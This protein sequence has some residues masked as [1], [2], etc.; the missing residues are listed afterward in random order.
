VKG[1]KERTRLEKDDAFGRDRRKTLSVVVLS[2]APE[3]G[4][5]TRDGGGREKKRN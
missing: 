1:E 2:E 4:G 5:S 3:R